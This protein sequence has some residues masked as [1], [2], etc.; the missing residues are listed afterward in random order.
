[1]KTI[2]RNTTDSPWTDE[3]AQSYA[4]AHGLTV[5]AINGHSL[6]VA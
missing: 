6:V 2:Q 1:M 3:E 4:D 5:I